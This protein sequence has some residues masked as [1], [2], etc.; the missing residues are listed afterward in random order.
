MH[1]LFSHTELRGCTAWGLNDWWILNGGY[2]VS[3]AA[4][5]HPIEIAHELA[6]LADSGEWPSVLAPGDVVLDEDADEAGGVG[7]VGL[8]HT[9]VE[10]TV[11]GLRVHLEGLGTVGVDQMH[12]RGIA[13]RTTD[14]CVHCAGAAAMG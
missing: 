9:R 7:T 4:G 11:R 6:V 10:L 12:R 3:W 13:A 14:G 8:R 2:A 5:P 1:A